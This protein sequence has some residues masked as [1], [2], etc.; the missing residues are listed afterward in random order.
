MLAGKKGESWFLA[1]IKVPYPF[2]SINIFSLLLILLELFEFLRFSCTGGNWI[3][4]REPL[5]RNWETTENIIGTIS[6]SRSLRFQLNS[7]WETLLQVH[8]YTFWEMGWL[9]SLHHTHLRFERQPIYSTKLLLLNM[10]TSA[11][12]ALFSSCT[13]ES[14]SNLSCAQCITWSCSKG[15][16]HGGKIKT[17]LFSLSPCK[18]YC[19]I[20]HDFILLKR[21]RGL[22]NMKLI[23]CT[24]YSPSEYYLY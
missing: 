17:M 15:F 23:N 12:P 9:G 7:C 10:K 20:H 14:L 19:C 6:L 16:V 5:I 18:G 8:F 21:C 3:I 4:S 2:I 1:Y 24:K 13:H 11:P 22:N